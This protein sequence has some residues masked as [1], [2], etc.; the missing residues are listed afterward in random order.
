MRI[1]AGAGYLSAVLPA[2]VVFG[3][4][5]ALTVAPV[6]ATV[7]AAADE[8]HAGIASGVNNA[9]ARVAGLLAVALL[10]IVAG[11]RGDDYRDPAAFSDGFRIAIL[12]TAALAAA[13]GVVALLTIRDDVLED[14][15]EAVACESHCAID[16]PPLRTPA[17]RRAA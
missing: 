5:L 15:R 2:L 4:G 16:A 8:R 1:E 9:V 13:G 17:E 10:P 3:L 14:E 6:T 11:I 12:V 7:L